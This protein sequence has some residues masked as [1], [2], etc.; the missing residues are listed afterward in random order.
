MYIAGNREI[1][2]LIASKHID[3]TVFYTESHTRIRR[4]R[5]TIRILVTL[6]NCCKM[7]SECGS[8][9][10]DSPSI[11]SDSEHECSSYAS[12]DLRTPP[13]KRGKSV[14]TGKVKS[15]W[16]LPPH[17]TATSKG[18]RFAFCKVCTSN[19]CISDGG[20]NDIKRHVNG[21]VH[22]HKLTEMHQ[23]ARIESFIL[24]KAHTKNVI[25]PS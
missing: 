8:A 14:G 21:P 25:S 13:R 15:S 12:S 11:Y 3:L 24:D 1:S 7:G 19:F 23:N 4:K 10:S 16:F 22:K 6:S 20:F 17:I 18:R 5:Y 2:K 9:V